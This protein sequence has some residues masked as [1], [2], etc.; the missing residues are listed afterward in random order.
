MSVFAVFSFSLSLSLLITFLI[1][2]KHQQL[3]E[4]DDDNESVRS[5]NFSWSS[6][7]IAQRTLQVTV[8]LLE[9]EVQENKSNLSVNGNEAKGVTKRNPENKIQ[10]KVKQ[11]NW[12]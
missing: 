9:N 2:I 1:I 8:I 7:N 11:Q 10:Y 6:V 5:H 4:F 3:F 12:K